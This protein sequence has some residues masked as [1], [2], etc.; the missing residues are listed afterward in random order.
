MLYS[1]QE[2]RAVT[3]ATVTGMV[4]AVL[5]P[6]GLSNKELRTWLRF[7]ALR[8]VRGGGRQGHPLR[9]DRLGVIAA[10]AACVWWRAGV[11]LEF[12]KAAVAVVTSLGEANLNRLVGG[13]GKYLVVPFSAFPSECRLWKVRKGERYPASVELSCIVRAVDAA[14][15]RVVAGRPRFRRRGRQR[16][17]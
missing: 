17:C 10:V 13:G 14:L 4:G 7:G 16:K 1:S 3:D 8:P 15:E 5:C 11:T 6:G 9:F 2:L 12:V